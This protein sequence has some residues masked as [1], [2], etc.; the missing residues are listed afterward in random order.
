MLITSSDSNKF[1]ALLFFEDCEDNK[2][3]L[4]D[5]LLSPSINNLLLNPL[6]LFFIFTGDGQF[7]TS[8]DPTFQFIFRE[9]FTNFDYTWKFILFFGVAASIGFLCIFSAYIIAS[10][11]VVSLFEYSL[12]IMSM[13]PGYFLFSEIPSL[14]TLLGVICIIS[15]GVY[16]YFREGVRKQYVA[17]KIPTRR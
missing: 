8:S 10:P 7:N 5:K 3:H 12:I 9:W 17:S 2:A 4:I 16:I 1:V 14:R 13:I 11:S 6:I 15:A